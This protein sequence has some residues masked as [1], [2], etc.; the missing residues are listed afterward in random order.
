MRE[1]L[2]QSGGECHSYT[3]TCRRGSRSGT[4][5]T[6]VKDRI[7]DSVSLTQRAVRREYSTQ[8]PLGLISQH[9]TSPL[10]PNNIS[11]ATRVVAAK[12]DSGNPQHQGPISVS[13]AVSR[14]DTNVTSMLI[15]LPW[16]GL[17]GKFLAACLRSPSFAIS[18][19]LAA[20]VLRPVWT[21]RGDIGSDCYISIE[22]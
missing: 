18:G 2:C 1:W 17:V 11:P 14:I 13:S 15:L 16:S 9:I 7:V 12:S 4:V 10:V 19:N 20:W 5:I 3:L 21:S 22:Q 6:P 8:P